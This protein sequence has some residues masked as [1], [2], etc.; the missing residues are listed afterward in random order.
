MG[1]FPDGRTPE[2]IE[3]LAG[4]VQEW[5]ADWYAPEYP[6]ADAVNPKGPDA[7]E[8]RVVRGG[9]Y[10]HARAWLR[11][12]ARDKEGPG[13]RMPWVGFRCARSRWGG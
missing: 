5:V 4:N 7:G 10:L 3:D 6:K 2:G 12:A 9:G 11:G 8:R 1:S 13:E